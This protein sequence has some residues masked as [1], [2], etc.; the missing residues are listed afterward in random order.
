MAAV[1]PGAAVRRDAE[2]D[3]YIRAR[4]ATTHHRYGTRRMGT[5]EHAVVDASLKVKGVDGLRLADASVMPDL[6]RGNIKATV[7]MIA[8]SATDLILGQASS[9]RPG[10]TMDHDRR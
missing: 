7:I 9:N 1:A 4:P 5:D 3:D 2:P 8:E 10:N 6:V